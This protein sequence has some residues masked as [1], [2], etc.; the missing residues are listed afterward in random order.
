M[1]NKEDNLRKNSHEYLMAEKCDYKHAPKLT[2][3]QLNYSLISLISWIMNSTLS[4]TKK[5]YIYS[6]PF[7][8]TLKRSNPKWMH[9]ITFSL[10]VVIT[11]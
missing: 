9:W 4:S 2:N 6:V 5:T 10:G 11:R 8:T 7:I 3:K 1:E